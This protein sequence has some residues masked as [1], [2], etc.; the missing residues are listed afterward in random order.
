MS[1]DLGV[2]LAVSVVLH[3]VVL[4]LVGFSW[5]SDPALKRAPD[6]PPFVQAVVMEKP[7]KAPARAAP[8][9]KPQPKPKPKPKPRPEPKAV[10]KTPAK[11]APKPTPTPKPAW[12]QPDM[13]ALLADEELSMDQPTPEQRP[14]GDNDAQLEQ[15]SADDGEQARQIA[16]Y[17]Q[18][19]I[20][21][22]SNRWILPATARA[23][24]DLVARVRIHLLPGG[25]VIDVSLVSSSGDRTFDDSVQAAVRAA[26]TLP[27]PS[28]DLF[29][30]QFRILQLEFNP[31]MKN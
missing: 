7:Q 28:G 26:G 24:D 23:R 16:S 5:D 29:H 12:Q 15:V 31:S 22:I 8:K 2:G 9:P 6:V 1:S 21:A 13:E 17:E 19:I 20:A 18:A 10:E 30:E 14:T 27:V 3:V 25:E 11:P 4:G